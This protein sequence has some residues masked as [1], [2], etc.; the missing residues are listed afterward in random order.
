MDVLLIEILKT[1]FW[2]NPLLILYK[3]AIQLNHEF[4]ADERVIRSHENILTYQKLL[5]SKSIQPSNFYLTS[6]LTSF[7]KTKKRFIMMTKTTSIKMQLIKKLIVAPLFFAILIFGSSMTFAQEVPTQEKPIK[8]DD[9]DPKLY[10]EYLK[11]HNQAKA[12]ESKTSLYE[13]DPIY[14]SVEKR[15][16]Y[17][18]GMQAFYNFVGQN[19]NMPDINGLNGKV[20]IQFVIEKDGSLTDIKIMRDIGH[21]TGEEA[22]RVLKL[23]AN[24]IPGERD[25]KKVRT[26]YSLPITISGN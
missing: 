9:V 17:P 5:L 6:N 16:E 7:L 26:L 13:Q 4:L 2:F 23:A 11:K 18:G 14:S 24:W 12:N 25:G 21:G 20:F 10:Q 19:F 15:P 3:R 22:V 1:I 8:E